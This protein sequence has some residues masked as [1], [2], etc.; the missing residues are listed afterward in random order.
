MFTALAIVCLIEAEPLTVCDLMNSPANGYSITYPTKE[1]CDWAYDTLKTL[2]GKGE[3]LEG[4][5]IADF[6]CVEWNP[7]SPGVPI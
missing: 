2:T 1:G 4:W 5:Y 7:K 3:S 6:T